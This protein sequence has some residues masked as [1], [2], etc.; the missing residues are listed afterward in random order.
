MT[1]VMCVVVG[2]ALILGGE[3]ARAEEGRSDSDPWEGFNRAIFTFN[4]AADRWVIEPVATGYDFIT[5]DPLQRCFSNFF[6]NLRVP[7]NGLNGLLQGKPVDG[8]SD[9]GRFVVN[10]TI[11]MAGFLD[12]ATYIGLPRHDEDFGQTLGV[13]GVPQGPYLMLPLLGPSTVRDAGGRAVDA[14]LTPTWYFIDGFITLGSAAFDM[15]NARSMVLKEVRDSRTA[16]LDFYV[17]VRNAYLQN[18][19]AKVH[20]HEETTGETTDNIYYPDDL[21]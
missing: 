15:L 5:P 21:R 16:A 8:A 17:F 1:R 18:R 11:G 3:S 13:W 9:V 4:D 14:A 6:Q 7:L 12:P 10:S 19:D 20:D 2:L